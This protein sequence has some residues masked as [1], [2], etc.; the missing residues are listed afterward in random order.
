MKIQSLRWLD[1]LASSLI[2]LA[3]CN[4]GS[5]S[6]GSPPLAPPSGLS[7]S[8]SPIQHIV[9]VVQENRTFNDFFATFPGADGTTTGKIAAQPNCSPPVNAG[10]PSADTAMLRTAP[11]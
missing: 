7:G 5:Q 2:V 4:G 1:G 10:R 11:V 8:R 3:D 6:L 9:I